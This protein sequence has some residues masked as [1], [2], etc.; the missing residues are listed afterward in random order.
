MVAIDR[1]QVA[2][3][4]RPFVPDGNLVV[5]KVA[6]VGVALQEPQQLMDDGAQMQ[7][8]GGQTGKALGQVEPHLV[9]ENRDRPGPGPVLLP[10]PRV[11]HAAHQVQVLAHAIPNRLAPHC[12]WAGTGSKRR[13]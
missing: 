11:A 1:P 2:V 13:R 6:D 5:L 10:Y 3:L 8:L 12:T 7:F 4:V 9:A